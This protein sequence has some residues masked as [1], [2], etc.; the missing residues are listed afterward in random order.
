MC[1][2]IRTV[3]IHGS[4]IWP[5]SNLNI[6]CCCHLAWLPPPNNRNWFWPLLRHQSRPS[7][8]NNEG[9]AWFWGCAGPLTKC[10]YMGDLFSHLQVWTPTVVVI[11]L[12]KYHQMSKSKFDHCWETKAD[13]QNSTLRKIMVLGTCRAPH[14]VQLYGNFVWPPSTLNSHCFCHLAWARSSNKQS[15]VWPLLRHQ[16]S[17]LFKP[18]N[19]F[20]RSESCLVDISE[21][22]LGL[23][24]YWWFHLLCSKD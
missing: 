21:T 16:S 9:K 22:C 6:H 11:W 12:G 3:R 10:R 23:H 19:T 20:F 2:T 5:P 1:E 4:L 14:K 8:P 15:W 13:L 17:S 24:T 18:L 7:K